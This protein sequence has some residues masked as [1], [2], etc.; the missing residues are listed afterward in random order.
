MLMTSIYL[1]AS[2]ESMR[3]RYQWC[4]SSGRVYEAPCGVFFD[5]PRK[6]IG[7]ASSLEAA[8][9]I[10]KARHGGHDHDVEVCES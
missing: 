2:R 9:A 1:K 5:P 3:L 6:P 4:A 7:K 10:A 8:I